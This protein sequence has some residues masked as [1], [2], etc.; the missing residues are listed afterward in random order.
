MA[1]EDYFRV[2]ELFPV[3]VCVIESDFK[4][5]F[6]NRLL[7]DWTGK[8]LK[9]TI[10][11]SLFELYPELS[12]TLFHERLTDVLSGGPPAI[13]TSQLHHSIIPVF[14]PTGEPRIQTTN[15]LPFII[16]LKN[17][18]VIVIQDVTEVKKEAMAYRRMKDSAI[19]A[20]N[21]RM[22]AEKEVFRA[23]EEANLYLDIMSHDI[24]N[25][26]TIILGYSALIEDSHDKK[27]SDYAR[28]I[29]IASSRSTEIINS[30]STIRRLREKAAELFSMSLKNAVNIGISQ[31][32][33]SDIRVFEGD[34]NVR[35]DDLLPEIFVNIVGNSLKYAGMDASVSI[36]AE[37]V[38]D[39]IEI[40]I[41]DD[42]PGIPDDMKSEVFGRQK[43]GRGE[44]G[45]GS[46][47]GLYIVKMLADRYGGS[48][49][50]SDC[51][52]KREKPGLKV[53]L[54]LRKG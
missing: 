10:G 7:C 54:S 28:R 38:G 47:L 9:K 11:R 4:I 16:D 40:C 36:T 50:L 5:I 33:K 20:L 24:A 44:K 19:I 12:E 21:D 6:W 13:F 51:M 42:G 52:T 39:M 34:F 15:V 31:F 43:R 18:A 17:V 49:R 46:G 32:G 27:I 35:A 26:N 2:M 37:N 48:I 25:I 23:N 1:S 41:C 3:G 45:E 22:E 29:S 8:D 14:L 53:C 30:V